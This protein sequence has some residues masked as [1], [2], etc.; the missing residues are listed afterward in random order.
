MK[1]VIGKR[2]SETAT[3][4]LVGVESMINQLLH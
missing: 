1:G 4:A 3:T 2:E